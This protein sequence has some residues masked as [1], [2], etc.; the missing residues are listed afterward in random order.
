MYDFSIQEKMLKASLNLLEENNI[1]DISALGGGTALSAYYWGHR[2][3]TDIDI[4]IYGDKDHK[5]L[6]RPNKW[7]QNIKDIMASLGYE[8]DY[9][10]QNIYAEFALD[11]DYKMQFFDVKQFTDT[12][13]NKVELWG[14]YLNIE[15]IEEIVAKKIHYRCE[16][17]NA[18][19]LFDIAI[20][21][22]KSPDILNNLGRLKIERIEL[23]L[24]TIVNI[25]DNDF[26]VNDY[27]LEINKMNPTNKY[28]N[29]ALNTINYL[30][31]FLE[32]YCGAYNMGM[33]LSSEEC[34]ELENI[35]FN[36]T[37]E[38]HSNSIN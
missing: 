4:F 22:N 27:I 5:N 33:E 11:Q 19:D 37:I 14:I 35:I 6:L 34:H 3:S 23:L 29:I 1:M 30:H 18:R 9:K 8:N 13:Y 16:K 20:A 2:F 32:S 36:Q 26:L 10:F 31:D 38:I 12:A 15:P 21:I 7:S 25:K 24:N 28:L 17:G